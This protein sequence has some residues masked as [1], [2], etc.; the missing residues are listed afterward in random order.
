[1]ILCN[2]HYNINQVHLPAQIQCISQK[3]I[4]PYFK[5]CE[6]VF[7]IMKVIGIHLP[8]LH[9]SL[10]LTGYSTQ[11]AAIKGCS[12][13]CSC[14]SG[15]GKNLL[16]HIVCGFHTTAEKN[17]LK[18]KATTIIFLT[19]QNPHSKKMKFSNKNTGC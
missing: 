17:Y 1:M 6:L 12:L 10:G 4:N 8:Q 5:S 11:R 9:T 2:S 19:F 14:F 7:H 3:K 16:P 13:N 15:L 18:Y